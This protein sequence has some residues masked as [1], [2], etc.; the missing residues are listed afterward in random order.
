MSVEKIEL[1]RV[2]H[3]KPSAF[4]SR[5]TF[6]QKD[7]EELASSIDSN[8]LIQPITVRKLDKP[9]GDITHELIAGERRWRAHKLLGK[10][11]ISAL[12]KKATDREAATIVVVE[13]LQREDL[14]CIE[15]AAAIQKFKLENKDSAGKLMSDEQ[16]G[17]LIGKSRSFVSN[18]IRLL[19]L[20][21]E[22]KTLMEKKDLEAW[23][24]RVLLS[25]S[26]VAKQLELAKK[27]VDKGL[28]VSELKVLV[29]RLNG[30]ESTK[31]D[32]EEKP[33][34]IT[35]LPVPVG[36]ILIKCDDE[37][38]IEATVESLKDAEFQVWLEED[39]A[40]EIK[41]VTTPVKQKPALKL[42][43]K[44]AKETAETKTEE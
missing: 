23:H 22:I 31:Q 12:V 34:A 1:V 21:E 36:Y 30:K 28:S 20:P 7:L 37:E 18:A 25:V 29:D 9:D 3:I 13:N 43:G 16:V 26:D 19:A 5:K 39:I 38:E 2:D 14:N 35:K 17:K 11:F 15:E 8:G 40:D 24:G 44:K 27:V 42:N 10:E 41:R 4:Q 32:G 6:N 33:K